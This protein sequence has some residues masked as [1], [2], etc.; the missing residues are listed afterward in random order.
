MLCLML[1]TLPQ[2]RNKTD[3]KDQLGE[4]SLFSSIDKPWYSM[5]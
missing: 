2:G 3:R 1:D 5:L 4:H